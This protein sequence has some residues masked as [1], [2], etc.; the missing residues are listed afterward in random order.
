VYDDL[1]QA[2]LH[3]EGL[4]SDLESRRAVQE[5]ATGESAHVIA[6]S[7]HDRRQIGPWDGVGHEVLRVG[8][9]SSL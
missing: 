4:G 3:V 5:L 8:P 9:A 6:T 7:V 2:R 1:T